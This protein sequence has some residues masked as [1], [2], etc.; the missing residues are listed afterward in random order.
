ME[1]EALLNQVGPASKIIRQAATR[2]ARQLAAD[3]FEEGTVE[4]QAAAHLLEGDFFIVLTSEMA[5][6]SSD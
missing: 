4:Y 6:L 3:G 5:R 1:Y 2:A